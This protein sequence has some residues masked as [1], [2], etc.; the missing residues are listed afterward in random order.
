MGTVWPQADGCCTFHKP[1]ETEDPA[2]NSSRKT[3]CLPSSHQE[4]QAGA[5]SP[6]ADYTLKGA[7]HQGRKPCLRGE[8]AVCHGCYGSLGSLATSAGLF[9]ITALNSGD[10]RESV[11]RPPGTTLKGKDGDSGRSTATPGPPWLLSSMYGQQWEADNVQSF[12]HSNAETQTYTGTVLGTKAT[13]TSSNGT[14]FGG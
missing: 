9:P 7:G 4:V 2:Q 13:M 10:L 14:G 5:N 8:G 11:G 12:V 1:E 6:K 3:A